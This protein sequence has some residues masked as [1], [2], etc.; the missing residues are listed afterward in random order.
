MYVIVFFYYI[1]SMT[2][3]TTALVLTEAWLNN[4]TNIS[5]TT[6]QDHLNRAHAQVKSTIFQLYDST[7][8]TWTNRDDSLWFE[9]CRQAETLIAAW[10][11]LFKEYAED[12]IWLTSWRD[13]IDEGRYILKQIHTWEVRLFGNDN[14]EFLR[15]WQM[16]W[17]PVI[18]AKTTTKDKVYSKDMSW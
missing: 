3:S 7:Y 12:Q 8:L 14:R 15:I 13:K 9:I 4:N 11:L 5:L 18:S 1:K 2:Y 16:V 6:V 17:Q 10:Y